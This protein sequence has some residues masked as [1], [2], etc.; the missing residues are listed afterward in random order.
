MTMMTTLMLKY[1]FQ[2]VS[3]RIREWRNRLTRHGWNEL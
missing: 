1:K 2:I 3:I